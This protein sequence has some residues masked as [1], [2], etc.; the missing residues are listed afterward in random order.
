[1]YDINVI[2]SSDK[3]PLEFSCEEIMTDLGDT[4]MF[5]SIENGEPVLEY[6]IPL[7]SVQYIRVTEYDAVLPEDV[8]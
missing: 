6:I 7:S 4:V 2:W 1:M 3:Q 8:H 5:G